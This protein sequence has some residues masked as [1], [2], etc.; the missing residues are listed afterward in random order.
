MIP[1]IAPDK[2]KHFYVGIA[3]GIVLQMAGLWLL[4]GHFWLVTA[5]AFAIIIAISYGFELF[6]KFTGK[7]HYDV[8]DAVA[9]II[10]GVLGMGI[11]GLLW[12][13]W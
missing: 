10:G 5:L 2:W 13:N 6:S 8:M 9:S 4:T 7:G 12:C 3:M 1:K 11:G